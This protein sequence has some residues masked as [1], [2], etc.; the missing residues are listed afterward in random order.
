MVLSYKS[1]YLHLL[2]LFVIKFVSDAYSAFSFGN[3]IYIVILGLVLLIISLSMLIYV[4]FLVFVLFFI[5]LL[6]LITQYL[7]RPLQYSLHPLNNISQNI[8]IINFTIFGRLE[9]ML[10]DHV[11]LNSLLEYLNR[12]KDSV[13]LRN[14]LPHKLIQFSLELTC[15]IRC[16][17]IFCNFTS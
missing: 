2:M 13:G 15:C 7:L 11:I 10:C 3:E 17:E 14:P 5:D 8:L 16:N 4:I 12:T 1:S 9:K 6:L